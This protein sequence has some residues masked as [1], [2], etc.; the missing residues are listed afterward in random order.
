MSL[1]LCPHPAATST[2]HATSSP[3]AGRSHWPVLIVVEGV[4]DVAFL[5][6]IATVWR[7]VDPELPDLALYERRRQI[8]FVPIGGGGA[9]DIAAWALRLDAL[10]SP[11]FH[12]HDRETPPETGRR[13]AALATID[14]QPNRCARITSKRSLENYLHPAAIVAAGGPALALGDHVDV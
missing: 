8:A 5:K 12:L 11:R 4:H 9:R 3:P 1:T 10:P 2:M 13:L 6:A 14:R 7:Q